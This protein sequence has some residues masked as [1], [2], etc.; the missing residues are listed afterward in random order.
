MTEEQRLRLATRIA[1]RDRVLAELGLTLA[2]AALFNVV[3]YGL[4]NA[5]AFVAED[6]AKRDYAL[7]GPATDPG[8]PLPPEDC[9]LAMADCLAKGWLRIVDEPAMAEI[10]DDLRRGGFSAPVWPPWDGGT[11]FTPAGADLWLRFCGLCSPD[12]PPAQGGTSVVVRNK[13]A[14]HFRTREVAL[15]WL[16]DARTCEDF[17]AAVGPVP[18]GPWRAQWWW[19]FPVGYRI[20]I[21]E[22]RREGAAGGCSSGTHLWHPT[23]H[24]PVAGAGSLWPILDR[25]GLTVAEW[26]ILGTVAGGTHS[27]DVLPRLAAQDW[28]SRLGIATNV[29][30]CRQGLQGCLVSGW[31]REVDEAVRAEVASLLHAE[32]AEA[33]GGEETPDDGDIDFTPVGAALY[34][35][36]AAEWAGPTWED[37]LRAC[38]ELFREE[39]FYGVTDEGLRSAAEEWAARGAV[40]RLVPL[41]PWCVTWWQR[42]LA[43]FR[44]EVEVSA[45]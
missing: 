2:E 30:H 27:A 14:W 1:V 9:R 20:D 35:S 41:G 3:H 37:G 11:D 21:E 10:L 5:P 23:V 16:E 8:G 42:H 33:A 28:T 4:H 39:H 24:G 13:T 32:P 45:P 26:L 29:E 43:G 7:G 38:K 19:R 34:R 12:T 17:H 40:V 18:V 6:A 25:H 44:L 36:I 31:V 15:A 22:R